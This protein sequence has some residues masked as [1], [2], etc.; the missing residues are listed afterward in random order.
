[1]TNR[2]SRELL[3]IKFN[4]WLADNYTEEAILMLDL[5]KAAQNWVEEQGGVVGGKD[6]THLNILL[7]CS[8]CGQR[9]RVREDG[10]FTSR[11]D[12]PSCKLSE[13]TV[14]PVYEFN[15]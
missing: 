13:T 8:L 7:S 2:C 5:A 10:N 9:T 14:V 1:M 11:P 12:E 6:L 15:K 4:D 3:Q